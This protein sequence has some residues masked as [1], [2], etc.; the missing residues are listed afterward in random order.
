[1]SE[2]NRE[3]KRGSMIDA[4]NKNRESLS[5]MPVEQ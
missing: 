5:K 1:M 3:S 4:V 2:K